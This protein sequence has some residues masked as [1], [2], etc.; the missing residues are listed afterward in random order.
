MS[1]LTFSS[2]VLQSNPSSLVNPSK[3]LHLLCVG[4]QVAGICSGEGTR[5]QGGTNS[6]PQ[7]NAR[8]ALCRWKE[9]SSSTVPCLFITIFVASTCYLMFDGII[10]PTSVLSPSPQ[11]LHPILTHTISLPTC[12]GGVCGVWKGVVR[13]VGVLWRRE[14]TGFRGRT[15]LLLQMAGSTGWKLAGCC[16]RF[17]YSAS[18]SNAFI[19][20][21]NLS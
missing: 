10:R 8:G 9:C 11:L 14:G 4:G 18:L 2:S 1:W 21:L 3:S 16:H 7:G 12:S 6:G 13:C 17:R 20:C 19:H 5:Y 15:R